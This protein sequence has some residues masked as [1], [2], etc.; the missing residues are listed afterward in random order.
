MTD[1]FYLVPLCIVVSLVYEATH[2]ESMSVVFR[3]GARL[4]V[5]LVGGI[6]GLAAL[7]MVLEQFL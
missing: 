3:R 5:M 1:L 2:T 7:L 6:V 4:S